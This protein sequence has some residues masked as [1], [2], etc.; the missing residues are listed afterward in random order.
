MATQIIP[1]DSWT[2]IE[3]TEGQVVQCIGGA[4]AWL[5]TTEPTD[6]TARGLFLPVMPLVPLWY[7]AAADITVY[8]RAQHKNAEIAVV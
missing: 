3:L 7:K 8:V 2:E 4:G 5:E 6:A 1:G